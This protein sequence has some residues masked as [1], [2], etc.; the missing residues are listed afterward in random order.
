MAPDQDS[1]LVNFAPAVVTGLSWTT[2]AWYYN[3]GFMNC[4]LTCHT[5]AMPYTYNCSHST[6]SNGVATDTCNDT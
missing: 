6:T 3:G 4:S 5:V 2:P 1:H